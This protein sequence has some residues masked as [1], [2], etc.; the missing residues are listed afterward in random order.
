M[1]NSLYL[2]N[3]FEKQFMNKKGQVKGVLNINSVI[4]CSMGCII[5]LM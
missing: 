3:V 1:I 5:N 2:Y 4:I